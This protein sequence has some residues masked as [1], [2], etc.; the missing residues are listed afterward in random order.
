MKIKRSTPPAQSQRRFFLVAQK[1][2]ASLAIYRRKIVI[3]VSQILNSYR[4]AEW[5]DKYIYPN[6]L[7]LLALIGLSLYTVS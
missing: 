6:F 3:F 2:Q 5:L 4:V 1:P 7:C